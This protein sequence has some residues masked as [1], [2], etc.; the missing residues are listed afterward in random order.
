MLTDSVSSDSGDS[1]ESLHPSYQEVQEENKQV[2]A[3]LDN[4]LVHP[5]QVRPT[6]A[7]QRQSQKVGTLKYPKVLVV[8]DEAFNLQALTMILD[9]FDE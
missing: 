9:I 5:S 6:D 4:Q 7:H 2:V 3:S 8:D 1:S